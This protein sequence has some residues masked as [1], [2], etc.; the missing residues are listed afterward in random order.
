MQTTTLSAPAP[1]GDRAAAADAP[2]QRATGVTRRDLLVA[3]ALAVASVVVMSDVW[4]DIFRLGYG[5]E[6]LSYVLLAPVMIAWIAWS[7]RGELAQCRVRGGWVGLIVLAA[8]YTVSAYGYLTDPVLWRAGAVMAAVGA[9][10]AALGTDVLR[11]FLPAFA[12]AV[13]LIPISPNGRYRLAVPMQNATAGVTQTVC[14]LLGIYVDRAGNLL[15][16]NGVDVTVAEA[17]NGMRMILTLFLVCYVV[18]FTQPLHAGLRA[19]LLA[20][21]PVVAI[22]SNVVRLVPTVWLFGNASAQTAE[23]FHD[24]SGW[25]MTVVAFVALMGLCRFL[26]RLLDRMTAADRAA[27]T[28]KLQPPPAGVVGAVAPTSPVTAPAAGTEASA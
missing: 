2:A 7:R 27:A 3:A 26:Q 24:V 4:A 20:A 10:V 25:V 17:C 22:V 15:T 1:L 13:F 28:L 21:S 8:G 23:R 11:K 9:V 5:N 16:I 18:A 19:L 14:D 6:E 12:A